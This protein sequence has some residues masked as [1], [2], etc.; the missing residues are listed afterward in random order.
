MASRQRELSSRAANIWNEFERVLDGLTQKNKS[1][2]RN[3][4]L[5]NKILQEQ[6]NLELAL[7]RFETS[8]KRTQDLQRE[9]VEWERLS[10]SSG[11]EVDQNHPSL[12]REIVKSELEIRN[13]I[14]SGK[15]PKIQRFVESEE[16]SETLEAVLVP[17]KQ[18][19]YRESVPEKPYRLVKVKTAKKELV[20]HDPEGLIKTIR[21][22]SREFAHEVEQKNKNKG[23]IMQY[24]HEIKDLH[25]ALRIL[26]R[27][28]GKTRDRLSITDGFKHVFTHH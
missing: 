24:L 22:V 27:T 6:K 8:L 21:H 4:S 13:S 9:L 11:T 15:L 5:K 26:D 17:E 7:L 1:V 12:R 14:E 28:K 23:N 10:K 16:A 20:P 18:D 2:G 25:G 3:L 19:E